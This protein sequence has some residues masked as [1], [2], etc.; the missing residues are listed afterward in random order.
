[1]A[2]QPNILLIM[3]DQHRGDCLSLENHPVLLTPNIDHIGGQGVHFTRAY[4]TC[5]SCVPARR[6]LMVGQY[7]ATHGMVGYHDGLEWTAP[8]TLPSVLKAAGY[9]TFLVGR[10]MHLW[11]RRQRYG[12]D[13]MVI[14]EDDYMEF[15]TNHQDNCP[16]G[17][18]DHGISGNGWTARPWHLQEKFHPTT[19]TVTQALHFLKRR[20]PSC[21]FLLVVSF[22]APH[23]P[24]VPPAFYL[25]RYLR[26]Q[27]PPPYLGDWAKPPERD[28]RGSHVQSYRVNLQG[29]ALR[30]ARAGYYGLINHVDDQLY[31]LL[32]SHT[33]LKGD[34]AKNT[35]IIFTSDHG[36]MLGDHYLFRKAY[37]YEGSARIPFLIQGPE[38]QPGQTC[39]C[40]VSLEDIMPTILELAGIPIPETVEGQSLAPILRGK[41]KTLEREYLHGEHAS[42]YSYPQANH[43]LTDGKE[44]Y[45]WFTATGEEQLFNLQDDPGEL[46]NLACRPEYQPRLLVWRERLITKLKNRPE[47]FTDGE[48][49][50]PGRP[51]QPLLPHASGKT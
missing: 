37:P 16:A 28:G 13:E 34:L 29:E 20:D 3:T 27:I 41:K 32:G 42:C 26:S 2:K 5:P 31:R 9:H 39:S 7:P 50:I 51:H 24:L 14:F 44:K 22:I 12:F 15:L 38:V 17:Y 25:E 36:E 4:S 43:F 11:P 40:P 30:A 10:N 18:W 8:P 23:P 19:W 21:P 35:Y 48:R 46:H 45:C 6:S 47:G 1:M 49:L 33:G